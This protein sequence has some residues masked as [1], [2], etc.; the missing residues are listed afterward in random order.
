MSCGPRGGAETG[1]GHL[2]IVG[3]K[4]QKKQKTLGPHFSAYKRGIIILSQGHCEY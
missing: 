3:E 1:L 4:G 2:L